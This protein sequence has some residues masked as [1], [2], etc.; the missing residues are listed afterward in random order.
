[1]QLAQFIISEVIWNLLLLTEIS[2]RY[3]ELVWDVMCEGRIILIKWNDSVHKT[4]LNDLFMNQSRDQLADS[5]ITEVM[6]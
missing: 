3:T 1:M 6:G 4:G 5:V 2:S